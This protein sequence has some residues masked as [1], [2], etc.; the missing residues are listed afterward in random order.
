[1][2]ES[3]FKADAASRQYTG[4]AGRE[5]HEGKRALAPG[6]LGWVME[7][8]AEK[9][10]FQVQPEDVVFE[11]GVGAGW[12]LGKLRCGRRIGSDAADFLAGP[13]RAKGIRFVSRSQEVTDASVDVA[14]CHHALEHLLEPVAALREL[15]RLLKP[16]GK[17]LLHV[18]WERET[19]YA[20]YRSAEPNHHLYT[21][22]AQ[23][24]GNLIS[25]VGFEVEQVGVRRYGYDRFAANL[26]VKLRLGATGFR[27][28]RA[29][30]IALRPLREVELLALKP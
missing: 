18:P 26:A 22:N 15:Q 11:L 10:Q 19:R 14:L 24:L 7:L 30:L 4:V 1:M 13:V 20:R 17:L 27:L 23:T 8:R 28:L 12:N 16:G 29:M 6:A 5:Y 3:E 21:W 9:F 2:Q 25:L